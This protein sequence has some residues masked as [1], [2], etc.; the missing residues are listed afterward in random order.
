M[1]SNG[2]QGPSPALKTGYD[3]A[4]ARATVTHVHARGKGPRRHFRRAH[5]KLAASVTA[6]A[7][8]LGHRARPLASVS[9]ARTTVRRTVAERKRSRRPRLLM[10]L[11]SSILSAVEAPCLAQIGRAHV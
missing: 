6:P 10:R 7:R 9:D 2:Y 4:P 8:R 1:K 5:R 11:A 3:L